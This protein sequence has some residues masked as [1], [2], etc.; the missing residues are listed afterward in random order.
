MK[1]VETCL[2]FIGEQAGNAEEAINF[3]T[4]LFTNSDIVDL[5]RYGPGEHEPEGSIRAGR[6]TLGGVGCRAM[7]S[8]L[9]YRFAFNPAFSVIVECDSL[10]ELET[11]YA[12]LSDGGKELMPLGGYGFSTKFSRTEDRY[13]VS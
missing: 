11:A 12:T 3:Y 8:H 5:D 4:S 9:D 7:D 1:Y 10:E 13:G 6:F 2:M